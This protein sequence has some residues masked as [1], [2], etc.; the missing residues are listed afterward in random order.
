MTLIDKKY[1]CDQLNI[2]FYEVYNI[3]CYGS[4]VYGTNNESSDD[5]Y[6]IIKKQPEFKIDSIRNNSNTINATLY[7]LGGF[8]D[9]LFYQE[10]NALECV[11]LKDNMKLEK[12]NITK[13]YKLRKNELRKSISSKASNSWVG[14]KKKF[15]NDDTYR[16]QKSV[17]HSLRI[18]D[19]GIQISKY[20]KIIN[21]EKSIFLNED[22]KSILKEI[23]KYKKWSDIKKNYQNIF[24]R[25]H[26]EFK[27]NF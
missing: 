22:F 8:K 1:I 17:F 10:I 26:S 9:K 16:A 20:G 4:K 13:D 23:M 14:S 25:F 5:D 18:F 2:N 15:W 27:L 11:W 24:N 7:N 6:I 12:F 21:Y 3:Y 19:F